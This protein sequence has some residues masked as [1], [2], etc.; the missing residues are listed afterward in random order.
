MNAPQSAPGKGMT[1]A[2]KGI[3]LMVLAMFFISVMGVATKTAGISHPIMQ[4]VFVRNFFVLA[5]V[6]VMVWR[7]GGMASL[8]VNDRKGV[9]LRA[10][11]Q[12]G[13]ATFI[14]TTV[15]LLPLADAEALFFAAPLIIAFLSMHFLGERVG[16]RR[17]TAIFVGFIGVIVML[18]PTPD[19]IQ[20][21][22]LFGVVASVF[23]ALRD[24]W[25]RKLR[26]GETANAIMFWSELGVIVGSLP[27]ALYVWQPL[28]LPDLGIIAFAG[29]VLGAAQF[30][31]A[32][33]FLTAEAATVAPFRYTVILLTTLFGYLF[34]GD[35]PDAF[36]IG[37]V[38]IVI[39]SGLYILRRE[40]QR[41]AG[42][43]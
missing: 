41:S 42:Q 43:A 19:L 30:T 14:S 15:I 10:F 17:K 3:L 36:V 23:I 22:A 20:P 7:K 37:G 26:E 35:I 40:T 12:F 33:A 2:T 1:P 9:G 5:L 6:L 39:A 13:A 8:K 4:V 34:F 31:M 16:W 21:I 28:T 27:F 32:V 25:T 38:A 24:I 11:F 29:I 18:R